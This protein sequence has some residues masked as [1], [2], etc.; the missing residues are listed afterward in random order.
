MNTYQIF[1]K[2][3]NGFTYYGK[4]PIYSQALTVK[5]NLE[6]KNIQVRLRKNGTWIN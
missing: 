1:I 3:E 6:A 4:T 2:T 5:A